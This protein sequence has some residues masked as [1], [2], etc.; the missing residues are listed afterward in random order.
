MP[1]WAGRACEVVPLDGGITNR[2]ARVTVEG[3]DGAFVVRLPGKRTDLLGID[4]GHERQAAEQAAAL[5][6]APE[7][8]AYLEPEGSL[9]TRFVTGR[10]LTAADVAGEHLEAAAR[11]LRRVHDGPPL[12]ATFDWFE[13]PQDHARVA[14]AQG[15]T[16]P[17]A[18]EEAMERARQVRDAFEAD[19]DPFVPC[20]DDL[21]PA[22]LLAEPDG[23]LW[24]LDWEYAGMNDRFF[25]L[26]NLAVNNELEAEHEERLLAA[27][28]DP[29]PVTDR[30]R[31]RL[32]LMKVMSDLREAMWGVVQSAV[33]DLDEDF[34]A[35]AATHFERL[36]ANAADPRWGELLAAAAPPAAR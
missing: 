24:L 8:V 33:S 19:P 2:N 15:G 36:L 18:Y 7:V 1:A 16:L 21:L 5:G 23:R 25:D 27:Y 28:L 32:A 4:R 14:V 31:A 9:V 34:D 26:G 35:Y 30:A 22:N 12:A 13:V 3:I 11:L 17:P 10:T 20:H 6:V 29:S